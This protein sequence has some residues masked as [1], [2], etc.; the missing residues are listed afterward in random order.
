[1]W[2]RLVEII[3]HQTGTFA[4]FAANLGDSIRLVAKAVALSAWQFSANTLVGV[5]ADRTNLSPFTKDFRAL[6]L[7]IRLKHCL[8]P[9]RAHQEKSIMEKF[10]EMRFKENP[11]NPSTRVT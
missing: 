11:R 3:G 4:I 7:V 2:S 1:M 10:F 6:A 9:D 8:Q 5:S